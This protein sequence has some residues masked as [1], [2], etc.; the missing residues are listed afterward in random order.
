MLLMAAIIYTMYRL[1]RPTKQDFIDFVRQWEGG[2]SRATTDTASASVAPGTNGIHTNKGITWRTYYNNGKGYGYTPTVSDFLKM[3]D[4]RW[5]QI[6]NNVYWKPWEADKL[7]VKDPALAFYVVQFAW[8]SGLQG[9]ENQIAKFQRQYMG[10][11]DNDITKSEAV[12][13]FLFDPVL[14]KYRFDQMI[15]FKADYYRSLKQP[16]NLNGW[17]NRLNDFDKKFN[18][19]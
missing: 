3:P 13:N 15:K 2:V 14:F 6:F 16:A 7:M 5:L 4:E 12:R 11:K 19:F 1:S 8:G 9:S 10:I 17:L 18:P